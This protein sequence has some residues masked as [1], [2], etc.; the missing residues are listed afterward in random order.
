MFEKVLVANRGEIAV[1]IMRTCKEMGINAVAVYSAADRN[2]LHVQAADEAYCIGP[3]PADESYLNVDSIISVALR[4]GA[5]AVHPGYGFLSENPA[6][7]DACTEAGLIFVGPS[8]Q[9][10]RRLGDKVSAKKLAQS[11]GVPIVPGYYGK[12]QDNVTLLRQARKIGFPVLIKAARGGGGRGMRLV[13]EEGLFQETLEVARREAKAA[14]GDDNLLL[15]RF[16]DRPRHIEIQIIGDKWGNLVHLGERECSIQRRYQKVMEESPSPAVDKELRCRLGE[17]AVQLAAA[18][19]YTNV[20]TVEF[21]LSADGSFFFLEVNPRIQVEHPVTEWTTGLDLVR[22]QLLEADGQ[23]L[24][25]R[26]E[27]VAIRGHVIEARIYAE[28]PS[29]DY[30][31]GAGTL[32]RF[33]P[34]IGPWIRNDVGVFEGYEV[35][36]FYDPLLAKL[37]VYG[38]DRQQAIERLRW[39]LDRYVILGATTNLPL[40]QAISRDQEFEAARTHTDFISR[41]IEPLIRQRAEV[42]PEVLLSATAYKLG[43]SG[44]LGGGSTKPESEGYDPWR[45][46]G[47]W[48]LGRWRMEFRYQCQDKTF[49]TEVSHQPGTRHWKVDTPEL[50]FDV[51][52]SLTSD[53]R[54]EARQDGE[55]WVVEARHSDDGLYVYWK[56]RTYL[57]AVPQI[58]LTRDTD[59]A[60]PS[61]EAV[62]ALTAPMP[63]KV[64]QVKVRDG[65]K[66]SA[67]QMLLV[68]E[69]MKMEHLVVAPYAGVV[70]RVHCREGQH[71]AKGAALLE[72][73]QV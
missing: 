65:E 21:L 1:R 61:F 14:S 42:P 10:L 7:V 39:A 37:I 4:C 51:E 71:V 26:Q 53:G 13:Q 31:P 57:L 28:D 47:P 73:E 35:P 3:A 67:H 68:L 5:Q 59:T 50:A 52:L 45:H 24:S 48:R 6:F 17:A 43:V 34:P 49:K 56:G 2:A 55:W 58:D 12:K 29:R 36:I 18:G 27:D 54:T 20:G 63:G 19:G 41:R 15:E 64:V 44:F 62:M 22:L 70:Q 23:H 40:L 72:L 60:R 30:L 16:L 69:A 11:V 46:M 33:A 32:L 8:A 9:A 66:V 38:Y 25:I